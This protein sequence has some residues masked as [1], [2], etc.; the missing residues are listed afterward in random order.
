[1]RSSVVLPILLVAVSLMPFAQ[2]DQVTSAQ[3]ARVPESFAGQVAVVEKPNW[4]VTPFAEGNT[5]EGKLYFSTT[6]ENLTQDYL[7]VGMLY[8]AF[9][10]DGRD[11][12][13]CHAPMDETGSGV[14]TTIAPGEQAKLVCQR[15]IVPVDAAGLQLISEVVEVDTVGQPLGLDAVIEPGLDPDPVPIHPSVENVFY[16]YATINLADPYDGSVTVLFR[17]YDAQDVQV[18]TCLEPYVDLEYGINQRVDCFNG[19]IVNADIDQPV[20][21]SAEIWRE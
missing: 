13:G 8:R 6:V 20:A 12:P 4:W 2:R 17:L 16:P 5:T 1:M 15:S 14:V 7:F 9:D 10:V 21:V 3:Q 19:V 18:D 11:V